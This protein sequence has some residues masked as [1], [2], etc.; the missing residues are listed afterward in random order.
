MLGTR[1]MFA[2]CAFCLGLPALVACGVDGLWSWPCGQG[3]VVACVPAVWR[4]LAALVCAVCGWPG[5]LCHGSEACEFEGPA[6]KAAFATAPACGLAQAA[7]F[8]G[9]FAGFVTPASARDAHAVMV[10]HGA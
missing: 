7:G 5:V 6:A 9:F 10:G 2:V 4:S 1:G 3:L 8:Q